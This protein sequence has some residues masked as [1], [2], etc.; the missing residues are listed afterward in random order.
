MYLR[1]KTKWSMTR[2][3]YKVNWFFVSILLILIAIMVYVDRVIVPTI[4]PPFVP[5]P[6][7][8]RSPESFVTEAEAMFR[9]GKLLQAIDLYK[10]AVRANPNDDVVYVA[11]AR[12]QVF[13]GLYEDALDSAEKALL[14]NANNSQAHAVRAWALD[15]L[16]DFL[17]AE[18]AIKRA[19]ELDP[20]NGIAHAYYVEIL[21]DSYMSGS[22]AIDGITKAAEES[23][24]ALALAPDTVEA[25]RARGYVLEATANYEEAIAEF[26]AAIAI[27]ENIPDLHLALGR[28]YRALAVYDLAV[29]EFTRANALNPSDPEPDRLISRTYATIGEYAKATQYAESAVKDAPTDA[30]LR[31]NYGV[32]LY[33][34]VD[35]VEAAA[36]LGLA[37]NGG[38]TENGDSIQPIPL[39]TD[40]RIAEYYFTYGLALAR[41]NR[42]G[43]ALQVAQLLLGRVPADEIAVANANEAIR[44]CEQNLLATA[45]PTLTAPTATG[46]TTP[47][48][49]P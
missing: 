10:Q 6:T 47:A 27:N 36:Q 48:P 25:H 26:Q 22:G 13:V 17:G 11:M 8:T 33:R 46:S 43:E 39:T 19:L 14:L 23:K 5:S 42:C 24:V 20:N 28:N 1:R 30:S 4:P 37:I 29:E 16:G 9:D 31:G 34:N 3:H 38:Q 7:P 35:W 45:V 49:T 44:I 12:A 15:F 32:M 40:T 2:K 18:A 21:V 41:L